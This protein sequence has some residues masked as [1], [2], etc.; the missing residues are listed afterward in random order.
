LERHAAVEQGHACGSHV[1]HGGSAILVIINGPIRQEI[2][3]IS[4]FN[5]LANGNRATAAIGRALRLSLINLDVRSGGID[6]TTLGHPEKF[7]YCL[8]EE[9]DT[10]WQPLPVRGPSRECQRMAQIRQERKSA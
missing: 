9:E 1:K 4:T 10:T 8:A 5:A 7:S 2:G 3:A 6:R